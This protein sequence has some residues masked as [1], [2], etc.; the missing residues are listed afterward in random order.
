MPINY[1]RSSQF[2]GG[3][4]RE[5]LAVQHEGV[6][7][8]KWHARRRSFERTSRVGPGRCVAAFSIGPVK[9]ASCSG[10]FGGSSTSGLSTRS[11]QPPAQR[12][13]RYYT[14]SRL[15]ELWPCLSS[16]DGR[17]SVVALLSPLGRTR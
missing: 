6:G 8:D 7:G 16:A 10:L 11:P 5:S 12:P 1:E 14:M 2:D 9:G 3:G 4:P 17:C 13:A 15:I